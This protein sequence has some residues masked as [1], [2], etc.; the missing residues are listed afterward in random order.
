MMQQESFIGWDFVG[1]VVNGTEDIWAVLFAD[2]YP[3]LRWE[4]NLPVA[5]AGDDREAYAWLDG[6]AEVTLDGSGSKDFDSYDLSYHWSWQIDSFIYQAD[7]VNPTITLPVGEHTIELTVNDGIDDSQP[8]SIVITVVEPIQCDSR[9]APRSIRRKS[10]GPKNV[11]VW[12]RL[13]ASVSI[14]Q[15]SENDPMH[16]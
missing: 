13:P 7:G 12:L 4:N 1:E 3:R 11:I 6:F 14:G 5:D 2:D 9:I 16:N 10:A 15:I 8:D